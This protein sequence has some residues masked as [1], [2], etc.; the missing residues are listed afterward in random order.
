MSRTQ[1][2]PHTTT[3]RYGQMHLETHSKGS[4]WRI[5]HTGGCW[6]H[7]QTCLVRN[8]TQANPTMRDDAR[9]RADMPSRFAIAIIYGAAP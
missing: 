9:R 7:G 2:T 8:H 4:T 6:Q 5:D 1:S 3:R